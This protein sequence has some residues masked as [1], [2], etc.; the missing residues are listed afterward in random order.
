MSSQ[1]DN[2]VLDDINVSSITT[3]NEYNTSLIRLKSNISFESLKY[4][5]ESPYKERYASTAQGGL[6]VQRHRQGLDTTS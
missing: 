5:E 6:T 1:D 4:S 2:N 3:A